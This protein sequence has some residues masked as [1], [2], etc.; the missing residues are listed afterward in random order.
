M[1]T[2]IAWELGTGLA[3]VLFIVLYIWLQLSAVRNERLVNS[4]IR[5]MLGAMSSE[6]APQRALLRAVAETLAAQDRAAARIEIAIHEMAL[7]EQQLTQ[8]DPG[9]DD[10]L[11][12]LLKL[13]E[14]QL[15]VADFLAEHVGAPISGTTFRVIPAD[16]LQTAT[17]EVFADLAQ[18]HPVELERLQELASGGSI[19]AVAVA[20]LVAPPAPGLPPFRAPRVA[21]LDLRSMAAIVRAL[22][23]TTRRQLRLATLLHGQAEALL[24]TPRKEQRLLARLRWRLHQIL[25]LPLVPQPEFSREDL[26]A[27]V[28]VFDATG[29]VIDAAGKQLAAGEPARAIELLAGLRMPVPAGLPGRLYHLESLAQVQPT[30][31]FG[32]WHRLALARWVSAGIAA[33]GSGVA[34]A[35]WFGESAE[36]AEPAGSLERHG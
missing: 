16:L 11:R 1:S 5:A 8:E 10:L 3:V 14:P 23:V 25:R 36:S 17:A 12:Q 31:V 29:E 32:V 19:A 26:E 4:A 15:L 27:L 28:V 6:L 35:H 24:R 34:R 13:P 9:A 21:D 2:A 18:D 22:D 33:A 20:G 30:A 7:H